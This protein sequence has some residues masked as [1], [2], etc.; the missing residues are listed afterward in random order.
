MNDRLATI[1]AV[2]AAVATPTEPRIEYR[3]AVRYVGIAGGA[4]APEISL[5]VPRLSR[6]LGAWM[7]RH[8]VAPAGPSFVRYRVVDT[9]TEPR[10]MTFEVAVP[11]DG[12][13]SADDKVVVDSLPAGRYL[14]AVHAGPYDGLR[15]SNARVLDW[16]ESH[17]VR[18]QR[19]TDGIAWVSRVA[20]CTVD[21]ET[22]RNP[23]KWRTELAYLVQESV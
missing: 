8:R 16:A 18:F 21:S 7:T 11:V 9:R 17:R 1:P 5:V 22:E 15:E 12:S 20:V 4:D 2:I 6:E 23:A 19:S 13:V 10:R 3:P 14:V